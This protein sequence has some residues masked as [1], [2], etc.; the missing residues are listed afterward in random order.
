MGRLSPT[1]GQSALCNW[2]QGWGGGE[3]EEEEGRELTLTE[4][5]TQACCRVRPWESHVDESQRPLL[6]DPA[7]HP[8]EGGQHRD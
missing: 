7:P 2:E 3:E 5:L 4:Y 1:P 8:L 6:R